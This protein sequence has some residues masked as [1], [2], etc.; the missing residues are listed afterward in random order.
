VLK[1]IVAAAILPI[2]WRGVRSADKSTGRD[3][4]A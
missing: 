4:E 2:A 3:A 1:A